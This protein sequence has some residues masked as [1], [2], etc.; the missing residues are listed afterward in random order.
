MSVRFATESKG[1]FPIRKIERHKNCSLVVN[2]YNSDKRGVTWR[3]RW[4]NIL[5]ALNVNRQSQES[6]GREFLYIQAIDNNF[7]LS[8]NV[9]A[10]RFDFR[11]FHT[12]RRWKVYRIELASFY[13]NI[14]PN[15]RMASG[16]NDSSI[17]VRCD[18]EPRGTI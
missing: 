2:S 9:N 7:G 10:F 8:F 5:C 12:N 4:Y 11:P 14:F 18:E 16:N 6:I 3:E 17:V 15:V 1:R 13:F